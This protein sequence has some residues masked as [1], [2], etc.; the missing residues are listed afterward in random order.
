[1]TI[2]FDI[3]E[4]EHE[5]AQLTSRHDLKHVAFVVPLAPGK[6]AMAAAALA[7]GPPFDPED[8]GIGFHQVLLTDQEAVFVFGLEK[9]AESLERILARDDFWAVVGWWEHV[10]G[11]RPRLAEVAYEWR[12]R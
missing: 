4:M 6:R 12:A 9:G 5:L 11:G 2:K 3:G 8:A 7:E 10:A 1:M